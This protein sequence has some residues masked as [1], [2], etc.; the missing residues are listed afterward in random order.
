ML[1]QC[2]HTRLRMC[3]GLSIFRRLSSTL[4][5]VVLVTDSLAMHHL[6]ESLTLKASWTIRTSSWKTKDLADICASREHGSLPNR[7]RPMSLFSYDIHTEHLS[8]LLHQ[9]LCLIDVLH[10]TL[11]TDPV[12]VRETPRSP[13]QCKQN[14]QNGLKQTS[15]STS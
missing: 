2:N 14:L 7:F 8:E 11:K 10:F 5:Y 6:Y 1:P 12:G 13:E 9:G 3:I 4:I 15:N